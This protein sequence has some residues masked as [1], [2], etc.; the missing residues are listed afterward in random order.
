MLTVT[1]KHNGRQLF[2]PVVLTQIPR[3]D[4]IAQDL[5]NSAPDLQI[6]NA[7][8]DTGATDTNI[9]P[10]TATLLGLNP[11][12]M[13]RVSHAGGEDLRPYYSFKVG[14][15][16]NRDDFSQMLICDHIVE[17]LELPHNNYQFDVLLGMDILSRGKLIV[18]PRRFEFSLEQPSSQRIRS[19]APPL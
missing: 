17:G 12:G 3:L 13:R 7:L 11:A 5:S 18:T 6:L 10:K 1:R 19:P 16:T 9:S 2:C 14:L 15:V 8:I 4:G